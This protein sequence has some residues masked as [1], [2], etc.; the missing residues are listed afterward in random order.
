MGAEIALREIAPSADD[1]ANL[2]GAAA[3]NPQSR[4]HCIRIA[5]R[6][7]ELEADKVIASAA[8]VFQKQRRIII[9][10]DHN[11]DMPVVEEIR[12]G[13]TTSEMSNGKRIAGRCRCRCDIGESTF[14]YVVDQQINLFV[15]GTR[16]GLLNV[17]VD[18][19]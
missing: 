3:L 7:D 11:I 13:G 16:I 6:A 18:V 10:S 1:F 19:A 12:E 8:V 17:G 9:I 14:A 15:M 4:A 5:P 2:H